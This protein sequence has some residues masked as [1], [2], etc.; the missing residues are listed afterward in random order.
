MQQF[1]RQTCS[2][3]V[4]RMPCCSRKVCAGSVR[5][6]WFLVRQDWSCSRQEAM[7]S[8]YSWHPAPCPPSP[9][10]PHLVHRLLRFLGVAAVRLRHVAH[11]QGHRLEGVIPARQHGSERGPPDPSSASRGSSPRVSPQT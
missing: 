2:E 7:S 8:R 3:E 9:H 6:S 11:R 5:R 4:V 1:G 10:P